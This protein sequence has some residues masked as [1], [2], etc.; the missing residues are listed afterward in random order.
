MNRLIVVGA[1]PAGLSLALQ[2]AR[3]GQR[4]S[5][6]E[7]RRDFSR[8]LRG[9][10]LMPCGLEALARMGLLDTLQTLPQRPLTDWQLWL[11]GRRLFTVPEPLG[12]L[13]PCTLVPQQA[14]LEALLKEARALPAFSWHPGASVS[15]LLV[16]SERVT[17]VR[18]S[19]GSRLA[20]DLVIACDGRDSALRQ[21]AGLGL[22]AR[23]SALELL[24]FQL[25][26]TTALSTAEALPVHGFLTLVGGGSI[27]SAC[28][29][30]RGD[31]QLGWVLRHGEAIPQRT[32]EAWAA[33]IANLAP[34]ELAALL[35]Q[36]GAALSGP[37]RLRVQMG[38]ARRWQRPGLLLLGDAAHPMSPIRAQ[39]INMA[40]RDSLVAARELLNSLQC[41]EGL[42]EEGRRQQL[43]GACLSIEALRRPEIARLQGLQLAEA[44]QGHWIGHN[45]LL[46]HG[47]ALASPVLGPVAQAVWTARQKPL[48]EGAVWL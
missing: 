19:D 36:Q 31:L 17:G 11:E 35:R 10:A 24:W 1:G 33:A 4:V 16:E 15:G 18:F 30:A 25:P 42:G 21:A 8:G 29:G 46:R 26:A 48:R 47:L 38:M 43:D 32:P 41:C 20:A 27:A 40:L 14:L 5:L 23:G 45:A 28:R 44:R 3:A 2:L 37:Q 7:A 6:L 9:D 12:A 22:Q 13:Q 34:P 39:G